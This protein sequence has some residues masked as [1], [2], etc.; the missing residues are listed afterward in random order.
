MTGWPRELLLEGIRQLMEPDPHSRTPGHEGV[1]LVPL[2]EG[3]PWGWQAV[4][5]TLYRE[6]ARKANF[7][8]ARVEDGRN[9]ARMAERRDEATTREDPRGPA[10]T[11]STRADPPSDSYSNTDKRERRAK[12]SSRVPA[13]F[14]PDLSLAS[15]LS[16]IDIAAEVQKFRDWEFKTPRSDWAAAWRNWVQRCRETGQYAKTAKERWI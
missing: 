10:D 11:D 6:K 14:P 8:A 12:R 1:R 16:G 9:A 4:N 5:H 2:V 7:D 3:R 13:D 15:G